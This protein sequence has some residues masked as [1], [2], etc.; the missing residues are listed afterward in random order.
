[1]L[2]Q[3]FASQDIQIETP[4]ARTVSRRSAARC[5]YSPPWHVWY[6]AAEHMVGNRQDENL[7]YVRALGPQTQC[8]FERYDCSSP[9]LLTCCI[10]C[11]NLTS[12]ADSIGRERLIVFSGLRSGLRTSVNTSFASR[13][14]SSLS[15]CVSIKLGTNIQWP[16][17]ERFSKSAVKDQG[18]S[19]TKCTAAEAFPQY[20]VTA[21]KL[22]SFTTRY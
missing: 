3:N 19:E 11:F 8:W 6:A 12:V 14:V 15:D 1:M 22:T 7:Q 17:R 20:G 10:Q 21:S 5:T 2:L 18:H 4:R 16:L 13:D 9:P